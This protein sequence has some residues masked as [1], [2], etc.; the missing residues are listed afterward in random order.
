MDRVPNNLYQVKYNDRYGV[1]HYGVV[2]RYSDEAQVQIQSDRVIVQDAIVPVR[3]VVAIADV[4]EVPLGCYDEHDEYN[5]YVKSEY[6][7]ALAISNAAGNGLAVGKLFSCQVAD[8]HATYMITKVNKAT[9]WIAWRGYNNPDR[10]TYQAFGYGG[11]FPKSQVQQFV[12]WSDCWN[13]IAQTEATA[14]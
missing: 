5:N 7:K 11:S 13:N 9:V 10:Y 12:D 4:T 1:L 6:E 14:G 8:G 2:D 3:Q